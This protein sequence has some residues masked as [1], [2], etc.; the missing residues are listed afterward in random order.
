MCVNLC[1]P[2][3]WILAAA[4]LLMGLVYHQP[5]G[6][7]SLQSRKKESACEWESA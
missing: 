2:A 1:V 3:L 5:N 4:Y 7:T 6:K